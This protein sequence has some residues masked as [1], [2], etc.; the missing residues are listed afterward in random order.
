ML[1]NSKL[2]EQTSLFANI[3]AIS[4]IL[5]LLNPNAH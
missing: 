2:N 4:A 5:E 1:T 3:L